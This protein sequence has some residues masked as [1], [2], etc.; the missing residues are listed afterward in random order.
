M[1]ILSPPIF[2]FFVGRKLP[3]EQSRQFF[4][5]VLASLAVPL[6]RI[7]QPGPRTRSGGIPARN[8]VRITYRSHR[9]LIEAHT[10]AGIDRG[11]QDHPAP[12]VHLRGESFI[13]FPKP[14]L[15]SVRG[16]NVYASHA[17]KTQR[18]R[19]RRKQPSKEGERLAYSAQP[20]NFR[21]RAGE[22]QGTVGREAVFVM[23]SNLCPGLYRGPRMDRADPARRP[24]GHRD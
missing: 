21:I 23:R 7:N 3:A 4:A 24:R 14:V 6:F 5:N 9:V 10:N 8:Q 2:K 17:V 20:Y 19:C 22:A 16:I 11:T 1:V 18:S 13:G 15:S 12:K